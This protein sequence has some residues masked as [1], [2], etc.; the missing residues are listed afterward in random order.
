MGSSR[1]KEKRETK[2]HITPRNG[3][4]HEKDEEE[5]DGIRKRGPGQIGL[6]N[7][8]QRPML[9]WEYIEHPDIVEDQSNSNGNEEIQLG[10]TANQ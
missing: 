9:H 6:E 3:N 5:L 1:P 8:G 2:E 7:A 4:R 10:S